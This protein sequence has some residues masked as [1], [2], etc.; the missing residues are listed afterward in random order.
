MSALIYSIQQKVLK[1]G[2]TEN[3]TPIFGFRVQLPNNLTIETARMEEKL[4]LCE[5]SLLLVSLVLESNVSLLSGFCPECF[6]FDD[7]FSSEPFLSFV[8]YVMEKELN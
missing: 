8:I 2:F 5:W 6:F 4:A 1:K 3:W 7:R